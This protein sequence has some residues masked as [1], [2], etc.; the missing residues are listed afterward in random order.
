[1]HSGM[2]LQ[3]KPVVDN[4]ARVQ[5]GDRPAVSL[6]TGVATLKAIAQV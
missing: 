6:R 5:L 1:M 2:K 3:V 4:S